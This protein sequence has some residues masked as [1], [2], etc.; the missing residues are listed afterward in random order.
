M[1]MLI[2]SRVCWLKMTDVSGTISAPHVWDL[3]L[4]MGTDMMLETS[5]IFSQPKRLIA[6]KHCIKCSRRESFRSYKSRNVIFMGAHEPISEMRSLHS[7]L[8][9]TFIT[10]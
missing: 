4:M 5:A 6:P 8:A 7:S 3:I 10:Y 2:K 1:E 9:L